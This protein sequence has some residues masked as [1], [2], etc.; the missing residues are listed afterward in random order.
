VDGVPESVAEGVSGFCLPPTLDRK[1]YAGLGGSAARLPE[2]VYDPA[3]D[4]LAEPRAVSP[5]DLAGA[6]R[7]FAE[8]PGLY[9]RM[10]AAGAE[11][12]RAEFGIEAYARAL[13]GVFRGVADR[14]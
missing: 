14:W 7:R 10:S 2:W 12:A 9:E 8:E 13:D 5:E 6:V 4:V 3:Q 11:R 1:S